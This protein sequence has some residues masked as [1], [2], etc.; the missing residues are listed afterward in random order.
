MLLWVTAVV[1]IWCHYVSGRGRDLR[2]LRD[3]LGNHVAAVWCRFEKIMGAGLVRNSLVETGL[4]HKQIR[5]AKSRTKQK[6]PK[7]G[8]LL[9]NCHYKVKPYYTNGKYCTLQDTRAHK[10]TVNSLYT[11]KILISNRNLPHDGSKYLT[12]ELWVI[13]N[14]YIDTQCDSRHYK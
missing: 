8:D 6:H 11:I 10:P 7:P 14:S 9:A 4:H 5:K 3:S 12:N 13:N 2:D 1:Y